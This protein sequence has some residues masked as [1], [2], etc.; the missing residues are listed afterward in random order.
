MLHIVALFGVRIAKRNKLPRFHL[1]RGEAGRVTPGC[2]GNA[3]CHLDAVGGEE[4]LHGFEQCIV[5]KNAAAVALNVDLVHLDLAGDLVPGL[6]EECR[7]LHALDHADGDV[8]GN[9]E[10]IVSRG[11]SGGQR[12]EGWDE[13]EQHEQSSARKHV[14]VSLAFAA[15][16]APQGAEPA[17]NRRTAAVP[18]YA[19]N[20]PRVKRSGSSDD[21]QDLKTAELQKAQPEVGWALMVWNI[22]SATGSL[23]R[24]HGCC[25]A[26]RPGQWDLHRWGTAWPV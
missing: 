23:L 11:R 6:L 8:N 18:V 19:R 16:V 24:W 15:R 2:I 3:A 10:L 7:V 5:G 4:G 25:A 20:V 12:K 9:A 17:G 22:F 26:R 13:K 21:L 14:W 1:A